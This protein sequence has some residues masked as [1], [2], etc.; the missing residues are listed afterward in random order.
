MDATFVTMLRDDVCPLSMWRAVLVL[1]WHRAPSLATVA[2]LAAVL[3]GLARRPPHGFVLCALVSMHAGIPDAKT[4]EAV[5]RA[6]AQFEDEMVASLNVVLG[7]G[8]QAAA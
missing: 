8:F 4:R 2:S 6:V 3:P 7:S 1:A 5:Q